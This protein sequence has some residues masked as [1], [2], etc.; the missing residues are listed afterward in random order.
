[1]TVYTFEK[2]LKGKIKKHDGEC[3]IGEYGDIC[4]SNFD[5]SGVIT[6]WY[7]Q[8]DWA[9]TEWE[10]MDMLLARKE[11]RIQSLKKQIAKLEALTEWEVQ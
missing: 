9:E 8:G 3:T 10:A 2:W 7:G 1:M 6:S 5:S 11:K 4:I